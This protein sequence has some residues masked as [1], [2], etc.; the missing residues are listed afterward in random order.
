[1]KFTISQ[2]A[3]SKSVATVAKAVDEKSSLPILGG[4]LVTAEG[5]DV[6]LR[7]T[8]LNVSIRR[9][10]AAYVE[11][12][13]STVVSGKMLERIVKSL[14]DSAVTFE[15]TA[16]AA[17]IS[18]EK[19]RFSLKVLSPDDFPEFPQVND[20]ST[21][22]LPATKMAEMA[23]MVAKAV[24]KD[25]NRPILGGINVVVGDGML[26]MVAT[27]S[28]RMFA[29]NTAVEGCPEAP[30]SAVLRAND[31]LDALSVASDA[32]TV[33]LGKSAS[34][35]SLRFGTT[36]FVARGLEGNY[37][38]WKLLLPNSHEVDA[39]VDVSLLASALKRVSVVASDNP[40]VRLSFSENA[41]LLSAMDVNNGDAREEVDAEVTGTVEIGLNHKF[42][43]DCLSS[44]K[45]YDEAAVELKKSTE[46]AV[47]RGYGEVDFVALL[48][49][50]RL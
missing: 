31:L 24:S 8:D 26:T 20:A 14:P 41:I 40:T 49:P 35:V 12:E 47:F 36:T 45:G 43:A 42:L 23:S 9:A 34:L 46:P 28:Y 7:A 18:C 44:L 39:R 29:C 15:S 6:T 25:K 37:P 13:G 2:S 21:V 32:D 33:E 5:N 1:M 11:E 4:I 50:V 22:E 48:M 27:D 19:A 38:N 16:T 10:A 30:V 17:N 3:L